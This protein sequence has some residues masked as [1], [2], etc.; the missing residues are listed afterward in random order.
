MEVTSRL[1]T[2]LLALAAVGAGLTGAPG[3]ATAYVGPGAGITMLGSLFAVAAAILLA[4]GGIV[5]FPLRAF[6]R[7]R[8]QNAAA[9]GEASGA[10][11]L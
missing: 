9:G 6:L 5:I 7:K 2:A 11:E 4:L 1:A 8:R 10:G 3:L